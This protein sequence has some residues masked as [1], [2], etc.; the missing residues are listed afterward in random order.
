M[1]SGIRF[2]K[3]IAGQVA[4]LEQI[5]SE[6]KRLEEALASSDADG[7]QRLARLEHDLRSSLS[8]AVGFASILIEQAEKQSYLEPSLI[9]KSAVAIQKAVRKSL[10]ILDSACLPTCPPA[11]GPDTPVNSVGARL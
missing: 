3:R 2:R 1:G 6:K 11:A 9:L 10:Q 8:V 7:K 4:Q 5:E